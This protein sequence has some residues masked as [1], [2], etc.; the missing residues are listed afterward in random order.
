L[1][2]AKYVSVDLANRN[3]MVRF[4][5]VF[6]ENRPHRTHRESYASGE[7]IRTSIGLTRSE[8]GGHIYIPKSDLGK[9][10]S[11]RNCLKLRVEVK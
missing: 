7:M 3:Q 4:T 10:E 11:E 2:A 5:V 1:G 8:E 9:S 6:I